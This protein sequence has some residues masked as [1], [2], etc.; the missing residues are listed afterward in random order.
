MEKL[1]NFEFQYK[2]F[3]KTLLASQINGY[4]PKDGPLNLK[5]I[6]VHYFK[7]DMYE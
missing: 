5:Q 1:Q 6:E 3:M 2:F 7:L 4:L